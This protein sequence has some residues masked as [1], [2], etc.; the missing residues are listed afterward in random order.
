MAQR[1]EATDE[2]MGDCEMAGAMADEA[3]AYAWF[4]HTSAMAPTP[5]YSI[6]APFRSQFTRGVKVSPDGLCLLSNADDNVLRL[7]DVN[8]E[9]PDAALEMP[10]GGTVYD[11]QWYPF[12]A[13][14]DPATCVFAT[15]SHA[16]PVHLWDAYTGELRATYRAYDHLDELTS[17]YSVAFNATGDKLFCGFERTIRFFDTTQPSRDF[18]TRAL[19]KTR[20]SRHGQRGII[21]SIHFNPDH[22]K[23]YAAGSYSGQTCIYAEDSGEE[24]LALEGHDGHGVTQVQFSPDGNLLLTGARKHGLIQVWDIRNTMQV[25]YSLPRHAPTNQKIAFDVHCGGRYVATGSEDAQVLLYDLTT[26]A[27][28]NTIAGFAG[29]LCS[30]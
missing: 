22:S 2:A 5:M 1:D 14:S 28:V 9:M 17:A 8:P 6:T 16:H 7:F 11:F 18:T 3:M 27:A 30:R 29:T 23:M 20:K 15:T 10:E 26:G 12:M 24:F 25:L 19:S 13:S 4:E 21:S